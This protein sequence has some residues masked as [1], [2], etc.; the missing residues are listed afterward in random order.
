MCF[1]NLRDVRFF[2]AGSWHGDDEGSLARCACW[3]GVD[4]RYLDGRR[5][6]TGGGECGTDGAYGGLLVEAGPGG[7]DQDAEFVFLLAY[8]PSGGGEQVE[9]PVEYH[10]V[11]RDGAA[12]GGG[13]DEGVV[14]ASLDRVY[15]A[16]GSPHGHGCLASLSRSVIS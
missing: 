14:G 12:V 5:G 8:L 15:Q 1:G 3:D 13:Q 7:G 4:Y 11:D 16:E 2:P 9:D 6:C 10:R